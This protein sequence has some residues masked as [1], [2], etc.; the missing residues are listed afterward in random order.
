MADLAVCGAGAADGHHRFVRVGTKERVV[1]VGR[2]E[3]FRGHRHLIPFAR[4][5]DELVR[6]VSHRQRGLRITV[7]Q[8]LI[9]DVANAGH[10][11]SHIGLKVPVKLGNDHQMLAFARRH[12]T[13]EVQDFQRHQRLMDTLPLGGNDRQHLGQVNLQILKRQRQIQA[14]ADLSVR[15]SEV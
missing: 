14:V 11:A 12:E 9:K 4:E 6:V 8:Q 2:E 5:S 7:L 15:V 3:H 10:K 13:H 1:E